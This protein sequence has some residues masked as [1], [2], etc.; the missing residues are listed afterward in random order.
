M[1]GVPQVGAAELIADGEGVV[2]SERD[3]IDF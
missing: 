3:R 2:R 1:S